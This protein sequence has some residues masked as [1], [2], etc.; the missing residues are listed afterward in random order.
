MGKFTKQPQSV[1]HGPLH[2]H[3]TS[4]TPN[5]QILPI[6]KLLKLLKLPPDFP[7]SH[8]PLFILDERETN[9]K[10]LLK[11]LMETSE[12]KTYIDIYEHLSQSINQG[13]LNSFLNSP[14]PAHQTLPVPQLLKLLK[15]PPH[16]SPSHLPSFILEAFQEFFWMCLPFVKN[17]KRKV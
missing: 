11:R 8:L 7:P 4:P 12:A 5:H 15:I 13:P 14:S 2:S 16:F 3:R 9:P 10:E 6:P 1:K 17:E